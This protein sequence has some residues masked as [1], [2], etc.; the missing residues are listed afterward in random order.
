MVVNAVRAALAKEPYD[1]RFTFEVFQ[2]ESEQGA[3]AEERYPFGRDRHGF[4]VITPAGEL[5]ACRPS[6][7]YGETEITA[8]LDEVLAGGTGHM[9]K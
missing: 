4:V 2:L 6:H 1:K 8:D 5:R 7:F 9:P 3:W